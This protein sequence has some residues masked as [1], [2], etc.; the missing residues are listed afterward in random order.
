MQDSSKHK[1][2]GDFLRTRRMRIS[3]EEAGLKNDSTRRRTPG[4]RREEVAALSGISLAWYT[5]LEQGRPIRVSEQVLESLSR[6]LKLDKDEKSYLF[7]LANQWLPSDSVLEQKENGDTISSALQ[8]ILDE[9]HP[10]PAY[11]IG[12]RWNIAAWNEMAAEVFGYSYDMNE[13]ERNIIWRM[14]TRDDYRKLFVNWEYM[15]SGLLGQ[16]RSF[17]AKYTD[18]PWYNELVTQLLATSSEFQEWWPR[19][20]VFSIPEGNKEM[21][22]P[23][24]GNLK[25]DYTNFLLAEEKNMF[26]TIFTPQPNTGT[27]ERLT[28]FSNKVT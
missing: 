22:H 9:L 15:A 18:G 14:F 24:L 23:K 20:E 12:N 26:L 1:E 19:H 3:P 17:Y 8:L 16:F 21:N 11:I 27:K 28:L 5:N 2:L 25:M 6:T 7:L 13:F 4:L 10:C